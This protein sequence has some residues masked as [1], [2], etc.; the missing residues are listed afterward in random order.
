MTRQILIKDID[1]KDYKFFYQ[2][3]SSLVAE[4]CTSFEIVDS[5]EC[6]HK[7]NNIAEIAIFGSASSSYDQRPAILSQCSK[8]KEIRVNIKR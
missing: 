1:A 8:C 7:F 2:Q 5:A 3:L 6:D 4:H